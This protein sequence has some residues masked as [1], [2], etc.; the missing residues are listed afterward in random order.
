MYL[1]FYFFELSFS[2]HSS[3]YNLDSDIS[4]LQFKQLLDI[5]VIVMLIIYSSLKSY[6]LDLGFFTYLNLLSLL[7]GIVLKILFLPFSEHCA[8]FSTVHSPILQTPPSINSPNFLAK[9]SVKSYST[10]SPAAIDMTFRSSWACSLPVLMS[11]YTTPHFADNQSLAS[12]NWA[13]P[14]APC[15]AVFQF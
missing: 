5:I 12:K 7:Q 2:R 4:S 6:L 13:G 14:R 3:Q 9:S 15:I 11:K 8:N 10:P 1:E